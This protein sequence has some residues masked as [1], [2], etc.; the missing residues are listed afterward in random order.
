MDQ[1]NTFE[2]SRM[3]M[4]Y[5]ALA[6]HQMEFFLES[7]TKHISV[8]E[9]SRNVVAL[10]KPGCPGYCTLAVIDKR[11]ITPIF[12]CNAQRYLTGTATKL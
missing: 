6:V 12:L 8:N 4:L 7:Q 11:N 9:A 1:H 10:E 5:N 2:I 3:K